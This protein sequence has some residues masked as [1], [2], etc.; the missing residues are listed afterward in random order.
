[1]AKRKITDT[2]KQ[3]VLQDFIEGYLDENNKRVYP[4]YAMLGERY[5]ISGQTIYLWSRKQNWQKQKDDFHA[6]LAEKTRESR[7]KE[8][9]EAGKRFDERCLYTANA[10]IQRIGRKLQIAQEV[11]ATALNDGR[12]IDEIRS[13]E[14]QHMAISLLN[15]QK[16]GK[17][18]LGEAQ[19]IQKVTADATIPDSFVELCR[20]V[21]EA[22]QRKA[23]TGNHIIN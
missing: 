21:E 4:S 22:G 7:V 10:I 6:E 19:E 11:E 23:Q 2:T 5:G 9:V 17:L 12:V 3:A 16:I 20:I 13:N 15:A 14:L 18:A 8:M 1:M